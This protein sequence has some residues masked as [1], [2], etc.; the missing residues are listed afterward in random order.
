MVGYLFS[1]YILAFH[2]KINVLGILGRNTKYIKT[3]DGILI[4]M[5]LLCKTI[6]DES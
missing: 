4:R 5:N 1:V 3:E 6:S 2:F